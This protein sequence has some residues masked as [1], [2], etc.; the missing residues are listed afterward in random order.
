MGEQDGHD[1]QKKPSRQRQFGKWI[2]G[3]VGMIV[4]AGIVAFASGLGSK[5]AEHI[6]SEGSP[7]SWSV[8]EMSVECFAGT[9][10]PQRTAQQMLAKPVPSDWEPIEDASGA[11]AA[12]RDAIQ[13]AI[14]GASDRKVTLTGIDFHVNRSARPAGAVFYRGCGGPTMGRALE[15]ELDS[16]PPK[17]TESSA[18]VGGMVGSYPD[19]RSLSK[20]IRFPWTVSMTDPLLLEI[21]GNAKHCYC[22]WTAEI[23]WV[24]G[25]KRGVISVDNEGDGFTVVSSGDLDAYGVGPDGDWASSG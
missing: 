8:E 5:A 2:A 15:V 12:G 21:I 1:S 13:V 14:Q 11:A 24:A 16:N 3:V 9:F 10:L 6:G 19:G 25:S 23:P 4:L 20:P 17:I 22:T 7:I 18:E